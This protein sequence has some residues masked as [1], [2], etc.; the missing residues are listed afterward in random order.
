MAGPPI[1]PDDAARVASLRSLR[2][3]DTPAEERFDRLVRLARRLFEVSTALV[4]FVDEDR[5][6][7]KARLGLD[8]SETSR[9]MSFCAHAIL[10]DDIMVVPDATLDSRFRDNPLVTGGPRIRFYAGR[11]VKAPDGAKLGTLC[12][13]D[14]QPRQLSSEDA[15][16]LGDLASMLEDEFRTAQIATTDELTGIT[17]RRGF[18]AIAVHTLA[19]CN[20]LDRPATL[21]ML[22]LDDF[23]DINDTLGH[24][25]GDRALQHFARHLLAAFRESDVV[26]RLGGDEFCVLLSGTDEADVPLRHLEQRLAAAVQ[27]DTS[28]P[29]IRFSAGSAAYDPDRHLTTVDLLDEADQRMYERKRETNGGRPG[30]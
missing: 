24:L 8:V 19:L 5:Q 15:Q 9:E 14:G 2:I 12:I 22:D 6:W 21:V 7:F 17:N 27:A 29:R 1:P 11:P 20:R 26:A 3:L 18:M 16:L 13:I 23:K 4:S 10:G 25:A 28:E 30:R